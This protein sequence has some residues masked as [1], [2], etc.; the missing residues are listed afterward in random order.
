VL[1]LPVPATPLGLR[2]VAP[3]FDFLEL[4]QHVVAVVALVGDDLYV[5]AGPHPLVFSIS[6]KDIGR[7]APVVNYGPRAGGDGAR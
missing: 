7:H 6:L 3:H 5:A 4:H 1:V 2:D